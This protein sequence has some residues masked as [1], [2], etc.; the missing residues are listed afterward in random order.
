MDDGRL[1]GAAAGTRCGSRSAMRSLRH[2]LLFALVVCVLAVA[3]FRADDA[4]AAEGDGRIAVDLELVLAVDVSRSIDEDEF[5]LQR[6][7]FAAALV[8]SA[9]GPPVQR[10][11]TRAN[12][13][14]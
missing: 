11:A 9:V 1:P 14:A 7:G 13:V 2:T 12:P 4:R 8:N 5:Q 10:C 6:R 3:A